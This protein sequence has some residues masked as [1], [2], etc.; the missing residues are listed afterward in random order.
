MN[1]LYISSDNTSRKAY[2]KAIIKA[3]R[4]F[5]KMYKVI[6]CIELDGSGTASLYYQYQQEFTKNSKYF[7]I[8]CDA[9]MFKNGVVKS[10]SPWAFEYK[11]IQSIVTLAKPW[12][13][14][15]SCN[16]AFPLFMRND[17]RALSFRTPGN[18]VPNSEC[19]RLESDRF[20]GK[21]MAQ[22]FILTPKATLVSQSDLVCLSY[23]DHLNTDRY[24]VKFN[25]GT[26]I[27]TMTRESLEIR[28]PE[29]VKSGDVQ[30]EQFIEGD[31]IS[32]GFMC[33]NGY[34]MPTVITEECNRL[35]DNN[36]GA[37]MGTVYAKHTVVQEHPYYNKLKPI[38][39]RFQNFV[40]NNKNNLQF[41]GWVD[42]DL[43]YDGE[44]FYLIEWMIRGGVSN[45]TTIMH[46]LKIGYFDL[47]DIIGSGKTTCKKSYW[48][49]T[50]S[51]SV[52]L[53]SVN[54]SLNSPQA[55]KFDCNV[56]N[57]DPAFSP[58]FALKNSQVWYFNTLENTATSSKLNTVTVLGE[59][60][61]TQR[62]GV[63]S[64]IGYFPLYAK[65]TFLNIKSKIENA[66]WRLPEDVREKWNTL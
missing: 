62:I 21:K 49:N 63:L 7:I 4:H 31:D 12:A 22:D 51:S 33:K 39:N 16:F 53:Y 64:M 65:Q 35:F 25:N 20:Y 60:S 37:K 14:F 17:L 26:Y 5:N 13:I 32:I 47:L 2:H 24:V 42:L 46:Q 36:G 34:C 41:N 19:F 6:L 9:S 8:Y 59:Y 10:T 23:L 66:A 1:S 55:Y 38:I 28:L 61:S 56:V 29:L 40:T 50:C 52:E 18:Y 58:S 15:D 44:N 54:F 11:D 45:F 27:D 30:V 48:K 57:T 43:R 3:V